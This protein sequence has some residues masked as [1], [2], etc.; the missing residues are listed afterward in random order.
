MLAQPGKG[1]GTH[2][3][4]PKVWTAVGIYIMALLGRKAAIPKPIIVRMDI[5]A[6][7]PVHNRPAVVNIQHIRHI[8]VFTPLFPTVA[9]T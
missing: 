7:I 9:A 4:R 8:T 2:S 1:R 5:P 3:T 6:L